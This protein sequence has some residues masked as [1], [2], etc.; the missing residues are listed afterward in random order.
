MGK[1]GLSD[2]QVSSMKEAFMLFDTD[3]TTTTPA[4]VCIF[5]FLTNQP[6]DKRKLF[7]LAK[8]D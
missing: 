2:D 8:L 6:D 5:H 3:A 7:I 4:S 1:D